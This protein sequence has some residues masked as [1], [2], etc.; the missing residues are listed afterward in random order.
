MSLYN[1]EEWRTLYKGALHEPVSAVESRTLL[2]SVLLR[3]VF[4]FEDYQVNML[5]GY[6][7]SELVL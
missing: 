3:T 1:V 6:H 2:D 4:L 7:S 5:R